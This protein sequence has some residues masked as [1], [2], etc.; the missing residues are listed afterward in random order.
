LF[1]VTIQTGQAAATRRFVPSSWLQRHFSKGAAES[2]LWL[3]SIPQPIARDGEG[4]T[5]SRLRRS[6]SAKT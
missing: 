5:K 2:L 6:L 1:A 4:G 3:Q